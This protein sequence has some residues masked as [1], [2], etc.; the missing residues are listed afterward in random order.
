ML[1]YG[2]A[3]LYTALVFG[4]NP[5]AADIAAADALRDGDMKKLSF[6]SEAK[7]LPV[8]GLVGMR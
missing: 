2:L 1:R 7:A 4:A 5:A 3:V 8:I 6:H